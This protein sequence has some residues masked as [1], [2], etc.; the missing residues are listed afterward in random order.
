MNY[1]DIIKE[2]LRKTGLKE[3]SIKLYSIKL[4]KLYNDLKGKENNNNHLYITKNVMNYINKLNS[5][6]DKLAYLNAIIKIIQNEEQLQKYYIEHRN[7]FNKIK[8]ENYKHNTQ[9]ANFVDYDT[10]LKISPKPDF[11]KDIK[12]VLYEMLLYMSIRYPMRLSLWNMKIAK[13]TRSIK[14]NENYLYITT[15]TAKFIMQ[16]FKNISSMGIQ[17][18]ELDKED[19][20]TV[21]EYLKY[22]SNHLKKIEY[23][24]YNYYNKEIIKYSSTDI[25]ARVLQRL[26]T[27]KLTKDITMNNIR[28]AY[29][30][31]IIQSPDYYKLTNAEKEKLHKRLLH[32][33]ETANA[34]YNK[35]PVQE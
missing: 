10:L 16:D 19:A 33:T 7:K 22:L 1:R 24:L 35:V 15:K 25:Y 20:Q 32:T 18:I 14:P 26:L 5:I 21:R 8:T 9:P 6:D 30:S 13:T 31:K 28:H 17:E 29:E 27:Q 4:N 12:S 11:N 2:E 23:L 34:N 3:G